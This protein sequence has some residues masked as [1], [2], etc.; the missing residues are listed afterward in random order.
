MG[1]ISKI[2]YFSA[3]QKKQIDAL[4]RTY[5]YGRIDHVLG[6]LKE[7]DIHMSRT[8]LHRYMVQLKQ[9]HGT[10]SDIHYNTIVLIINQ[11]SGHVDTIPL[12]SFSDVVIS[13]LTTIE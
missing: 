5:E 4:I 13:A 6:L 8:G 10:A 9:S 7:Q 3:E 2:K 12:K 11:D 1:R